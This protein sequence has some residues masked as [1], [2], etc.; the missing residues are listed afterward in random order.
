MKLFVNRFNKDTKREMPIPL[1][2]KFMFSGEGSYP[3]LNSIWI[4]CTPD[5][6]PQ[7]EPVALG[8]PLSFNIIAFDIDTGE[9]E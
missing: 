2:P 6:E 3:A 4:G 8:M 1:S 9:P 5:G 7:G